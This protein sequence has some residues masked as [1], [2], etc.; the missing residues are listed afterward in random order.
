MGKDRKKRIL[1]VFFLLLFM[2]SAVVFCQEYHREAVLQKVRLAVQ[3]AEYQKAIDLCRQYLAEK[4]SDVEV[5]FVLAQAQAFSGD[6][7]AA[8]ETLDLILQQQPDYGDARELKASVERWKK[9]RE[10]EKVAAAKFE[11]WA[12][13]RSDD[14]S[15]EANSF[16]SQRVFLVWRP[17]SRLTLIPRVAH[18]RYFNQTDYQFGVEAY[19]KLWKRAYALIDLSYATPARSLARTSW[20]LEIYQGFYRGLEASLGYWKMNFPTNDVSI[21][22][23]S[24]GYYFKDYYLFTRGYY[25]SVENGHEFSWMAQARRYFGSENYVY[26]LF[27]SG[28]RPFEISNV[29]DLVFIKSIM[30]GGGL[31]FYVKK[32]WKVEGVFSWVKEKD[33]PRRTTISFTTGYRF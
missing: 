27:G 9:E 14:Y 23:G 20:W 6:Y 24:L 26:L 28:S 13:Y 17:S 2:G 10:K 11:I 22:L 8:L 1:T 19:P 29:G 21:V 31:N 16:G 4:E 7:D 32:H 3:R 5:R 33:G 12:Q 15:S 25:S 30:F 18:T